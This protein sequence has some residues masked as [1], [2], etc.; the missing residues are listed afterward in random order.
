M[1][2]SLINSAAS[3]LPFGSNLKTTMFIQ[4]LEKYGL[5]YGTTEEFNFRLQLFSEVDD[6][7]SKWNSNE[8]NTHQLAHNKFSTWTRDERKVLTGYRKSK[9]PSGAPHVFENVSELPE[10]VDWAQKGA[11]TPV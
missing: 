6:E 1:I 9:N 10:S 7:I 5:S 3:L 8:A 2:N 4:H 11:V